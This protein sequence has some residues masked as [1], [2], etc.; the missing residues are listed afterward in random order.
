M[1]GSN[2]LHEILL[3]TLIMSHHKV[4]DVNFTPYNISRLVYVNRRNIEPT[5]YVRYRYKFASCIYK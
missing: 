4:R 2:H 3:V 5:S 1:I